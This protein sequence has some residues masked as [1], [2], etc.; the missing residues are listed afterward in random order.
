[1]DPP[2]EHPR[3]EQ[4]AEIVIPSGPGH[5]NYGSGYRI[6][7]NFVL[8]ARHLFDGIDHNSVVT[9]RF[10]GTQDIRVV[11]ATLAWVAQASWIDIALLRLWW[12]DITPSTTPVRFGHLHAARARRIPFLATGFPAFRQ[13][14]MESGSILRDSYQISG[15]IATQT[16]VKTGALE[17]SRGGRVLATGPRWKGTSGAA[18][19]V[20]GLLVGLISEADSDGALQ[21]VPIVQATD[22]FTTT[23]AEGQEPESSLSWLR[24]LLAAEGLPTQTVPARRPT[25]EAVR[26]R[27]IAHRTLSLQGRGPEL[28]RLAEFSQS[29]SSYQWWIGAPWAGKT[30]LAA[31]FAAEPPS[32]TDVVAF[33]ISRSEGAQTRQFQQAVCDQLASI[34]DEPCPQWADQGTFVALW[35]RAVEQAES[36]RRHLLLLVDGL[37]EN[38]E[39]PPIAALL[40]LDVGRY[41]HVLVLSRHEPPIPDQVVPEHPIRDPER[42][43]RLMLSPSPHA[44]LLRQ[45]A[46]ADLSS[47]LRTDT[48]ARHLFGL[49][50]AAGPLS[51]DEAATVLGAYRI[52]R[53]D[54][55]R[56]TH[57]APGRALRSSQTGLRKRYAFAHDV[58][59]AVTIDELGISALDDYRS[60]VY[61]WADSFANRQWSNDTPDYLLEIYPTVLAT[62]HEIGRLT[63]LPT[64]ERL[65]L[66]RNRQG[67]D[68]GAVRELEMALD[69]LADDDNPDIGVACV[70][71]LRLQGL[72]D[73]VSEC[74]SRSNRGLGCSRA[75]GSRLSYCAESAIRSRPPICLD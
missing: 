60:L 3:L 69:T 2:A 44:G 18:V 30:A 9:I 59:R 8:T 40:P 50:A 17:L 15:E 61:E 70:L 25:G 55:D 58:L 47:Y 26:I 4:I 21:A 64:P 38:D 11:K 54:I 23:F 66:W 48:Q 43:P 71:A 37:D 67:H 53:A 29:S 51:A 31:C 74:S 24:G 36:T 56:V 12:A 33:F 65:T 27:Q 19:F 46:V 68:A 16:N 28:A 35:H 49:L 13:I 20:H 10:S 41:A 73:L 62:S 1:M 14:D 52:G 34:I 39:L 6:S 22:S 72:R 57:S 75:L 32:G 45:R 7:P 42:C 5:Y 63:A